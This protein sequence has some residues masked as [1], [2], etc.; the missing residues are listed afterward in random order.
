MRRPR[1]KLHVSTF[2]FLAVLLCAMGALI[3]FL[4]V[5]DRR[6]K[7]VARRKAE[8]AVEDVL[9]ERKAARQAEHDRLVRERKAD[10]EKQRDALHLA[11]L[12][13]QAELDRE[14]QQ[15][16]AQLAG[17]ERKAQGQQEDQAKLRQAATAE[18]LQLARQQ[19]LLKAGHSGLESY[20]QQA[21][22]ATADL[23]RL[24]AEVTELERV[25]RELKALK[26]RERS[27]YSL[28]PYH[29]KRGDARNPLYVECTR[30][31]VIFH[32]D[33]KTLEGLNLNADTMR[34]EVARRAG[35]LE[36]E[37]RKKSQEPDPGPPRG[38]YV[39]FLIRPDGITTYYHALA[40]LRGFQLDF[41]YEMVDPS[42]VLDFSGVTTLPTSPV[43]KAPRT[44]RPDRPQP[45]QRITG[46][47]KGG[48]L[49]SGTVGDAPTG[50]TATGP[51]TGAGS[52]GASGPGQARTDGDT[53]FAAGSGLPGAI[54]GR[55]GRGGSGGGNGGAG[56]GGGTDCGSGG[57]TNGGAASGTANSGGGSAFASTASATGSFSVPGDMRAPVVSGL[58]PALPGANGNGP[59]VPGYDGLSFKTGPQGVSPV[60]SGSPGP[61]TAA[62]PGGSGSA[63]IAGP[64][65]E[66]FQSVGAGQPGGGSQLPA[67][68]PQA[69]PA[70]APAGAALARSVPIASA[71]GVGDG[72]PSSGRTASA[73]SNAGSSGGS[74]AGATT[75]TGGNGSGSASGGSASSGSQGG[76]SA[77]GGSATSGMPSSWTV[78]GAT[79]SPTTDVAMSANGSSAGGGGVRLGVPLPPA[80]TSSSRRPAS[81]VGPGL[82]S[83][84][85]IITI[86]CY[87]DHVTVFPGGKQH[88]WKN[89]SPSAVEDSV[90]KNV[91]ALLVGRYKGL[92]PG[93]SP[94][95]P[96]IR[97]QLAAGGLDSYLRLYP[98]LDVLHV[99]MTRENLDE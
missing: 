80:E 57:R 22:A 25:L 12:A 70:W 77:S 23:K 98:G 28:V 58:A 21:V 30:A 84:D 54:P 17:A 19:S 86:T 93:E 5:I 37:V 62:I 16:Q 44:S 20:D 36:R 6:G 71:A 69:E 41:G 14:A 47:P 27:T 45:A 90:V 8:L 73:G 99:P 55:I 65:M 89:G 97:F 42:W 52:P 76:S 13:Q 68:G 11:L 50:G 56:M 40:C 15:A 2:P 51:A 74:G 95:R 43:D 59:A 87:S 94:Y 60:P 81:N 79:G 88:W 10:W 67:N 75:P 18:A 26:E 83:R 78:P 29:G 34:A 32:P 46:I 31:G 48:D 61:G 1:H 24:T 7:I 53:G 96:M 4:L 91:Q 72:P 33:R 38:P 39:L 49:V 82:G 63:P 64:R 9:A 66:L 35:G 3:L 92:Q 85:F